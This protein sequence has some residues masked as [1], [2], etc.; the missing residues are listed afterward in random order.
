VRAYQHLNS[1]KAARNSRPGSRRSRSMRLMPACGASII[2][3]R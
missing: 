3:S 2:K 1:S